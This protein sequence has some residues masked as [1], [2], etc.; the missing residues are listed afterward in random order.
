MQHKLD[1]EPQSD[2]NE[3]KSQKNDDNRSDDSDDEIYSAF[4]ERPRHFADGVHEPAFAVIRLIDVPAQFALTYQ[5]VAGQR[6]SVD[7]L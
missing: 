1:G 2:Q 5:A 7:L 3:N 6:G 4:R